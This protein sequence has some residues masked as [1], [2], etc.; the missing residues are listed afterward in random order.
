MCKEL[1]AA[2]HP[3]LKS[4]FH[5]WLFI[6][7]GCRQWLVLLSILSLCL[8]LQGHDVIIKVSAFG[9]TGNVHAMD[10]A[11]RLPRD[12]LKGTILSCKET[13]GEGPAARVQG[14]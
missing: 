13:L 12:S 1:S 9:V 11:V 10:A 14:G 8:A 2:L 4:N 5:A 7:G 6:I 3:R